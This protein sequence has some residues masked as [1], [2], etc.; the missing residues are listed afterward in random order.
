MTLM[1]ESSVR[2]SLQMKQALSAAIPSETGGEGGED[3]S[4]THIE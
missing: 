4:R 1:C 2:E 3:I